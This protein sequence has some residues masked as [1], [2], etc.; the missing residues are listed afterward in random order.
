MTTLDR[1]TAAL[2][3]IRPAMQM[4]GGDIHLV[5]WRETEG[6]VRVALSGACDGCHM[7]TM[8]MSLGVERTLKS[9]VPEV[10]AVETV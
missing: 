2:E 6:L 4:D 5:E 9:L 1:I 7:S 10:Q 8:T 3:R